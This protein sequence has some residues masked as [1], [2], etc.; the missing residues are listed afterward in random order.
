MSDDDQPPALEDAE[1]DDVSSGA[2]VVSDSSDSVSIAT[3][4]ESSER[5]SDEEDDG[6]LEMVPEG[7]GSSEESTERTLENDNVNTA[8]ADNPL[9]N[10]LGAA[11]IVPLKT[12]SDEEGDELMSPRTRQRRR[13]SVQK[14]EALDRNS[15][16]RQASSE[17]LQA[18]QTAA[19]SASEE[20][21]K[22]N[23]EEA[24]ANEEAEFRRRPPPRTKSGDGM[25]SGGGG[26][27]RRPPPR[28][29]SGDGFAVEPA[30]S[31]EGRRRPP[32]R[33]KSGAGFPAENDAG[34]R[35]RPPPRTKS[36]DGFGG[37]EAPA[38]RRP[39]ARTKSGDGF[40]AMPEG[41]ESRQSRPARG[42]PAPEVSG[43]FVVALKDDEDEDGDA[44]MSPRR[45]ERRADREKDK[46]KDK[47]KDAALERNSMRRQASSD[48]LGA[49]RQSARRTA[50]ARA[51]SSAATFQ[52]SAPAR[53]K[54]S[55]VS[56]LSELTAGGD[57]NQ[58]PERRRPPPRTKSGDGFGAPT[59]PRRRPPP[60]T[61]S[62]AIERMAL[63]VD[64]ELT[65]LEE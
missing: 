11:F 26:P 50:P 48:M 43:D 61:K 12:G 30:D 46:G 1:I 23:E 65:S 59:A 14:D 21:A 58:K 47:D 27:R 35:R 38:R 32:P 20:E 62:G 51:K 34:P 7:D 17:M 42:A 4:N 41:R 45:R 44:M 36:G 24:K 39:P 28:S 19:K 55:E 63:P 13:S 29:K 60:R 64:A 31:A 22:A 52:R 40:S 9:G 5:S 15:M 54:S 33:T 57:G 18:M 53:T 56:G 37:V 49:M 6:V 25:D 2:S 16:R 3:S 8:D 10:S